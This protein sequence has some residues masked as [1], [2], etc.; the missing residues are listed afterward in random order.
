VLLPQTPVVSAK[1]L[2]GHTPDLQ[3]CNWHTFEDDGN[4]PAAKRDAITYVRLAKLAKE[5]PDL[6]EKIPFIDVFSNRVPKETRWNEGLVGGV[7]GS[8]S[9]LED[10]LAD[11]R[12]AR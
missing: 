10:P 7:S 4:S 3:G 11:G 1:I 5:H 2:G 8:C 9:A 6:C 12:S